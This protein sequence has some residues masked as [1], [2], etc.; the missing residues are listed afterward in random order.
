MHLSTSH[1]LRCAVDA[2][3]LFAPARADQPHAVTVTDIAVG[4]A[5]LDYGCATWSSRQVDT[6]VARDEEDDHTIG[7]QFVHKVHRGV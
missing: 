6:V 1:R 2:E 3:H 7:G 4:C 5:A